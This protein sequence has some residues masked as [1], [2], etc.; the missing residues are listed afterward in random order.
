MKILQPFYYENFKCIGGK[1]ENT[2]CSGWQ[3]HIDKKSFEKY[4]KIKGDFGKKVS[5]NIKRNRF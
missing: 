3:I 1:C 4:K 5:S 2:C